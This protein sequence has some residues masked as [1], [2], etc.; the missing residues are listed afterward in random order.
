MYDTDDDNGHPVSVD[1]LVKKYI[2]NNLYYEFASSK[3]P[4]CSR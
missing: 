4:K 1:R 2:P 3:H